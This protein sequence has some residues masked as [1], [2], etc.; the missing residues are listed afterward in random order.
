MEEH[1]CS[2]KGMGGSK[3]AF[4]LKRSS[5]KMAA[6]SVSTPA[7]VSRT[8]KWFHSAHF[9]M[10]VYLIHLQDDTVI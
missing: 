7:E 4:G 1:D 8:L 3:E 2:A 9:A 5:S 6:V 10:A